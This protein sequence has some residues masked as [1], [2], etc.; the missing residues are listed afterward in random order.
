[1]QKLDTYDVIVVGGGASGMMAAGR[2]GALGKKVL[3]IEKNKTLGQKLRITGGGRCNVTNATYDTRVFLQNYGAAAPFL[4]S[5]FSQFSAKDT[6]AFFES[7]GLP[8]VV[9]ALNRAF[10][11]TEKATD[12]VNALMKYM[13]QGKVTIMSSTAVKKIIH[14]DGKIEGV[15]VGGV[16]YKAESYILATGGVSHPETGS[17]GDGFD[18]LRALGHKVKAPT[19]SIV[20]LEVSD[21][22]IHKLSGRAMNKMKIIFYLEGKKQLSLLGRVLFTHFGLS[23]PLILN[24]ASKVGDWL[25]SGTV[26]ASIDAFPELDIGA[27]DHKLTEIFDQNKNK[28]LKNVLKEIVPDGTTPGI[29][30][31]LSD[32]DLETKVHSITKTQRRKIVDIL[33]ALPVHVTNLM[34]YDKAVVADGGVALNEVDTKTMRSKLLSNLFV[35]GDLLDINRPSG[36]YS[37]QACWTSG[38][39]AGTNS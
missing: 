17:T 27:L 19:P 14:K 38:Y 2:A 9:Q 11:H 16:T 7:L 6:F 12:V 8:L 39:V 22:W 23:G 32:L 29:A 15:L 4:S 33:K 35:T 28:I 26:T 20:P 34:G 36:G 24:S 3:L 1:M 37:L 31:L 25:Q 5:P 21:A 13:K 10:P 18:W 30:M